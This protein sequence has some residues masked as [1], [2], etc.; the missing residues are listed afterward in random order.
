MSDETAVEGACFFHRS[1]SISCPDSDLI[2]TRFGLNVFEF[3]FRWDRLP[4]G[5]V[6][7]AGVNGVNEML[8]R[9]DVCVCGDG[10][11]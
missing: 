4:L 5:A 7:D 3:E 10:V 9:L 8:E 2:V 1:R 11:E 6:V